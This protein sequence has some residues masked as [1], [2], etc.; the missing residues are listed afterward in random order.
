MPKLR[1]QKAIANSAICSRRKAEEYILQKRVSVNGK[2]ATIGQTAD[3]IKDL[4]LVDGRKLPTPLPPRVF[5]LNKPL[6]LISSCKDQREKKSVLSLIPRNIRSG[7]HPVGRLD[8]DTRGVLLLTNI[9]DLT[10]RLTHPRYQHEKIYRALVNGKPSQDKLYRWRNGVVLDGRLTMPAFVKNLQFVDGK[11]LLE[12]RIREGRNRQIRRVA[13]VL[14]HQVLDLQRIEFSGI[15]L[16]E[17]REGSWR[18]LHRTEWL[19]WLGP[20]S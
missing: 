17:L 12:I 3:P 8:F 9:G 16:G 20:I 2:I 7:L 18:E 11:S 6:G 14:G 10:L 4:I 19:H 13:E 15:C 1:L 5:L